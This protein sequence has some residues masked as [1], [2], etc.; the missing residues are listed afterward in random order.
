M[1]S[2]R[3]KSGDSF[4]T[5]EDIEVGHFGSEENHGGYLGQGRR[6]RHFKQV[7]ILKVIMDTE[8]VILGDHRHKES[9]FGDHGHGWGSFGFTFHYPVVYG[10]NFCC[11]ILIETN[12]NFYFCS[13]S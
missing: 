8:G 12:P 3:G 1:G 9:L 4:W 5:S 6:F 2:I 10:N 11:Y 13:L 7:R